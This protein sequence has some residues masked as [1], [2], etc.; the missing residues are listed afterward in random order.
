M[1][2]AEA[3]RDF[4]LSELNLMA[5]AVREGRANPDDARALLTLFCQCVE[6]RLISARNPAADRLLEHVRD[7][8]QSYLSGNKRSIKA[9]FGLVRKMGRPKADEPMRK[10]MAAEVL[11]HRLIGVSHREA[12]ER[13]EKK[14]GWGQTTISDAWATYPLSA[15]VL[16]KLDRGL[17]GFT[18]HEV[19][20]I[21]EI[22]GDVEGFIASEKATTI[23]K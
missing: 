7:A 3:Q 19:E 9:A 5:F 8:L 2:D 11:R 4:T 13:A 14:F 20:R 12:L 10:N 16:V 17:E 22:F 21:C 23:T 1:T 15:I 6:H 18:S